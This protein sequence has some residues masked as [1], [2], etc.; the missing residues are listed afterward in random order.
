MVQL[1][2][3]PI[4]FRQRM[5]VDDELPGLNGLLNLRVQ[6]HSLGKCIL[7]ITVEKAYR[8]ATGGLGL[9]HR[10]IRLLQQCRDTVLLAEKDCDA[11]A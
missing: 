9:I 1:D 8:I 7:D 4:L 2:N 3:L 6:R 11:D 5:V 10:Q